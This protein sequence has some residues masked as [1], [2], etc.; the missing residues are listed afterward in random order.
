MILFSLKDYLNLV[1]LLHV[2]RVPGYIMLRNSIVQ[3]FSAEFL[4]SSISA[5]TMMF[6]TR[7]DF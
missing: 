2:A 7:Y 6:T 3:F 4:L 1:N 5:I